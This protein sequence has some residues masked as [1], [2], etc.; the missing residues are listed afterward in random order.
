VTAVIGNS[1][2]SLGDNLAAG[3][4]PLHYDVTMAAS[5]LN[6]IYIIFC[7]KRNDHWIA[8][9]LKTHQFGVGTNPKDAL[10]KGIKAADQAAGSVSEHNGTHVSSSSREFLTTLAQAAQAL[11]EGAYAPGVVYK[12]ERP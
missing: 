3:Q 9:S 8:I 1:P 5:E 4:V 6:D 11:P 10:A 7:G 2:V 12:Y